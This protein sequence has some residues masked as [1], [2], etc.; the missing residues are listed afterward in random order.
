MA[1][2]WLD[3]TVWKLNIIFLT[4]GFTFYSLTS[5]LP[6]YYHELGLPLK[7]GTGLLT[8][9][10][11]LNLPS[12][13]I[14][15]FISD[16][17]GGIRASLMGSCLVLLPGVAAMLFWPLAMPWLYAFF[18]GLAMGGIFALRLCAPAGVRR[19]DAGGQ[20][21]RSQP[22]GGI[23]RDLH[24]PHHHRVCPRRDVELQGGVDG[25]APGRRSSVPDGLVPSQEILIDRIGAVE[26]WPNHRSFGPHGGTLALQKEKVSSSGASGTASAF[27]P[28]SSR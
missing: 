21:G 17:A 15:P 4:Q 12:S 28:R 26:G 1:G 8:V 22:A 19:S 2:L 13:L 6:T 23:R 20:R 18:M 10:I 9:F 7:T 25:R 14:V 27:N 16:K 5:W 24:R 11:L 3:K